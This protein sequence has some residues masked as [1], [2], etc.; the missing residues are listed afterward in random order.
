MDYPNPTIYVTVPTGLEKLS[1]SEITEKFSQNLISTVISAGRIIITLD[2]TKSIPDTLKDLITRARSIEHLHLVLFS[3]EVTEND[4]FN[5]FT[6]NLLKNEKN[7][8]DCIDI[9]RIVNCVKNESILPYR[10]NV[11]ESK[12]IIDKNDF[13]RKISE[14][15][16]SKF[17][18]LC[19]ELKEYVLVFSLDKVCNSIFF[20]IKLTGKTPLGL[21]PLNFSKKREKTA[22]TM[23]PSLAYS[24]LRL[25]EI[26]NGDFI[27]DPMSGSGMFCELAIKEFEKG[28]FF[29]NCEIEEEAGEKA[30]R[31]MEGLESKGN[32][33]YKNVFSFDVLFLFFNFS[34]Y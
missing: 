12:K 19:A 13:A 23:R 15:L 11:K 21:H 10:I 34:A 14:A 16:D 9:F 29:I 26:E 28:F 5:D 24:L 32:K 25:L 31:N 6:S 33:K 17:N 2:S 7:F 27:I 18:F 8:R 4:L 30:K 20:T 3:F 22:A 1:H